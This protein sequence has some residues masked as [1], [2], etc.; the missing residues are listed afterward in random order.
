[1]IAL[2]LALAALALALLLAG[3]QWHR[4]GQARSEL[5]A[6]RAAVA[7]QVREAE[8]ATRAEEQRRTL[9][10]QEAQDAEH[11]ARKS[12]EADARR[13]RTAAERLRDHA[14]QLAA[15]CSPGNPAPAASS[16]AASAPGD[17]L[18]DMQRRIDDAA[19]SLAEYAD[20]ARI[21]GQLCERAH[22]AL[23]LGR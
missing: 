4:A 3:W 22:D 19:G 23:T 11:L 14:A 1:M 13:A 21:A 17:L 8:M 5:A 2:R 16:P 6:Y 20:Q 9:K 10:I 7:Q 12:A 18:A 15:R